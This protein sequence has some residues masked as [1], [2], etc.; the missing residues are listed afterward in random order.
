M[1][2]EWTLDELK[3]EISGVFKNLK[4]YKDHARTCDMPVSPDLYFK[5]RGVEWCGVKDFLG[6]YTGRTLVT[7]D[8]SEDSEETTDEEL[9]TEVA[10]EVA[11]MEEVVASEKPVVEKPKV[12]PV[13]KKKLEVKP[14]SGVFSLVGKTPVDLITDD[15]LRKKVVDNYIISGNIV[16]EDDDIEVGGKMFTVAYTDKRML[17]TSTAYFNY[18]KKKESD[19]VIIF[20]LDKYNDEKFILILLVDNLEER[21]PSDVVLELITALVENTTV[22][23][24][25]SESPLVIFDVVDYMEKNKFSNI[26]VLVMK[27]GNYLVFPTVQ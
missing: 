22:K 19:D 14:E 5:Q 4:E 10:E 6:E 23:G 12:A 3:S 26:P 1:K 8:L 7:V 20:H 16:S 18:N 2:K 24:A 17:T 25:K 11:V 13:I 9:S 15:K 27:N 21:I